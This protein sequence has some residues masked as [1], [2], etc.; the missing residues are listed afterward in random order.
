MAPITEKIKTLI[1]LLNDNPPR[2]STRGDLYKGEKNRFLYLGEDETTAYITFAPYGIGKIEEIP[3]YFFNYG[4][5]PLYTLEKNDKSLV[6]AGFST[7][8][9][10]MNERYKK[11]PPP[12]PAPMP[13]PPAA[14]TEGVVSLMDFLRQKPRL[15]QIVPGKDGEEYRYFYNWKSVQYPRPTDIYFLENPS[16]KNRYHE[17]SVREAYRFYLDGRF[18][19]AEPGSVEMRDLSFI[20]DNQIKFLEAMIGNL[21]TGTR[22]NRDKVENIAQEQY[23]ISDKYNVKELC[24]L[25]VVIYC[26]SIGASALSILHKYEKIVEAYQAQVNLSH[27]TSESIMLQQ[28]STPCPISFMAGVFCDLQESWNGL[29]GVKSARKEKSGGGS[30][31]AFKGLG[32][33]MTRYE[34]EFDNG[35]SYTSYRATD[36]A[37]AIDEAM[38][39]YKKTHPAPKY[40]EPSAGNGLLTIAGN[41]KNFVVNEISELRTRDLLYQGFSEVMNVDAEYP[42]PESMHR[43]FDAIVTNPPF[44]RA[45]VKTVLDGYHIGTLEHVMAINALNCMKDH[46]RAAVIVGG[47]SEYGED[48][49]I[50]KGKNRLF[51]AYLYHFYNVID[52]INIDGGKL[53]A[54]QGTSF[55]VR[56]ILIAGRAENKKFPFTMAQIGD[57]PATER[58]S[59]KMVSSW[60]D[61]YERI[62]HSI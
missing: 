34:V 26:R 15:I 55:D 13:E 49:I 3:K 37:S 52:I 41:P 31:K 27:R 36:R 48:G 29:P 8:H 45:E 6:P 51:Y 20:P 54:K 11:L 21:K 46:G 57:L 17:L 56:L 59:P 18:K 33:D 23:S 44:G 39:H 43:T 1:Q 12:P 47:V 10:G 9:L 2:V 40:F 5:L 30:Y 24:E 19:L 58:N 28:Y 50:K 61:F 35:T 32:G 62:S 42:F 16:S 25:A 14:V 7:K 38:M 22:L 4:L 53:Y 60:S